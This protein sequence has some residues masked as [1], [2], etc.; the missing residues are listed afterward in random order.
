MMRSKM[1][2]RL[3]SI[4]MLLS[5]SLLAV[6][7][8][9]NPINVGSE[10][11][12]ESEILAQMI[13]LLLRDAG[14]NV[15]DNTPFGGTFENREALEQGILDVYPEYTAT[16]YAN[17]NTEARDEIAL[18][19]IITP[20]Q[21]YVTVSTLDVANND[22]I[23]LQPAPAN[24]SYALTLTR[25]FSEETSI[26]TM[27]EFAAYVNEGN[28]VKLA[29]NDEFAQFSDGLPYF[30]QQ[31]DFD[32]TGSQMIVVIGASPRDTE[33]ALVQG[34]NGINVAMAF[35]TDG[36]IDDLDLVVLED[37][38]E[39]FLPYQPAPVFRAEIIREYPEIVT[40]LNPVF[41]GITAPVLRNLNRRVQVDGEE[42][43][44][45]ALD[46]LVEAGFLDNED[47]DD[48]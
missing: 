47:E 39:V 15:E 11:F 43:V 48:E 36:T 44:V 3:L 13:I 19:S 38:L 41:A 40:I 25:A 35:A 29:T 7:A 8:Q 1:M 17:F 30:E 32:I 34:L 22:I 18:D 14:L 5:S 23:W 46:Y 12:A 24:N 33:E 6:Q 10:D 31:Y 37:D 45:V 20:L 16:A 27:S 2:L 42:P 28:D 26:T 9:D 21:V 4:V